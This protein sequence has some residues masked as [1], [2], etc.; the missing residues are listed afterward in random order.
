V[1]VENRPGGGGSLANEQVAR[2][3]DG[4]TFL[5]T[6]ISLPVG[7]ALRAGQI[8]YDVLRDLAPVSMLS[9]VANG[10]FVHPRVA[11]GTIAEFVALAKAR[12]GQLNMGSPGNG[13]SGHVTQ[14]Y[15]KLRTGTDLVHVPY[16]GASQLLPDFLSGKVDAVIDNLP[17]YLP[18]VR[19]GRL[20]LLAVTTPERWPRV[21]EVPTVSE[22]VVPGFDVR[23]WF[24][25]VA[26]AQT[27]EPALE[28]MNRLTVAALGDPV[29]AGRIRE[30]GAEPAPTSRADFGAFLRNEMG[31]WTEVV[32]VSGA[33]PD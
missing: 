32:R 5:S 29:L 28:A 9:V 7:A 20:K 25:L 26:S 27:P 14:E 3:D 17:L 31:R 24:G 13:T 2:A 19:E 16:R 1:V 8:S 10:I 33:R 21:P 15:F 11:A 18:H 30:G 23:A 4:H 12:P 6:S 22:T